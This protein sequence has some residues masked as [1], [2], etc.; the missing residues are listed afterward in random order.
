MSIAEYCWFCNQ[1][2]HKCKCERKTSTPKLNKM[3]NKTPLHEL[4]EWMNENYGMVDTR[5]HAKATELL[6]KENK[7]PAS[8]RENGNEVVNLNE[9]GVNFRII[10]SDFIR[11]LQEEF[12]DEDLTYLYFAAD[13]YLNKHASIPP[14]APVQEDKQG[15]IFKELDDIIDGDKFWVRHEAGNDDFSIYNF[16]DYL[17]SKYTLTK[18]H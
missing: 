9:S 3:E 13:K 4:I 12:K 14:P 18:K 7:T 6:E 11:E 17:K 15:E 2:P 1:P 10:L 8:D 5:V 16:L